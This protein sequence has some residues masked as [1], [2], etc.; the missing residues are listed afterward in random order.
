M[1]KEVEK[2][3]RSHSTLQQSQEQQSQEGNVQVS[4]FIVAARGDE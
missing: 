4:V 1:R 2:T 3:Q